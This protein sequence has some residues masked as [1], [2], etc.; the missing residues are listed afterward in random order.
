M[1][2]TGYSQTGLIPERGGL[3]GGGLLP[4]T[5]TRRQPGGRQKS[6]LHTSSCAYVAFANYDICFAARPIRVRI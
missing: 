5:T 2:K 4:G 3:G 1:P 6:I